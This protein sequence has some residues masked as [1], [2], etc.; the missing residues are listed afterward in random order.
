M[1]L[2]EL[3]LGFEAGLSPR[4]KLRHYMPA[5]RF[6]PEYLERLLEGSA[7][8]NRRLARLRGM[9]ERP[10]WLNA[11]KRRVKRMAAT[12][13]LCWPMLWRMERAL[14]RGERRK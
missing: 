2:T 5:A 9:E 11:V 4:L 12:S 6:T 10:A 8:S 14:D 7:F 13:P 3:E 1:V